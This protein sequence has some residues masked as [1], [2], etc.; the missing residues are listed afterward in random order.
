MLGPGELT[1]CRVFAFAPALTSLTKVTFNRL[2]N[3]YALTSVATGSFWAQDLAILG[4][5]ARSLHVP[6]LQVFGDAYLGDFDG[7][8]P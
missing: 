7:F 2:T 5:I 3:A 1:V 4:N 8:E 6:E